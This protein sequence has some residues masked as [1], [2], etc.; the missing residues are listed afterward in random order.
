VKGSFDTKADI[1]R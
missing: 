1:F